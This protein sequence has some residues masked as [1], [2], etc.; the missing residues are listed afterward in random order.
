MTRIDEKA[1]LVT[2]TIKMFYNCKFCLNNDLAN[3]Q[4]ADSIKYN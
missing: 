1:R 3:F 4:Y 2:E